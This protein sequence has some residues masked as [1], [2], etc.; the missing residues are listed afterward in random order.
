MGGLLSKRHKEIAYMKCMVHN[1]KWWKAAISLMVS[2]K[3]GNSSLSVF[4]NRY[5]ETRHRLV[6]VAKISIKRFSKTT[7]EY[8]MFKLSKNDVIQN[9]FLV[10]KN[11]IVKK[12]NTWWTVANLFLHYHCKEKKKCT[13]KIL[14]K[15]CRWHWIPIFITNYYYYFLYFWNMFF[16]IKFCTKTTV[17]RRYRKIASVMALKLV[18]LFYF[19]D[20]FAALCCSGVC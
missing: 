17:S 14:G 4:L 19:K 13:E 12:A 20:I 5:G 16:M 3:R 11:T 2:E 10:K 15:F 1:M 9:K 18:G 8:M 7:V 6:L